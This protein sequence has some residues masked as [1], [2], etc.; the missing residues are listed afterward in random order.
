MP[1]YIDN[2]MIPFRGMQ[3]CHMAA[4]TEAEMHQMATIIGL[5]QEW[6]T[7]RC[8]AVPEEARAEAVKLGAREVSPREIVEVMQRGLPLVATDLLDEAKDL[9][10]EMEE[11]GDE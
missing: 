5:G 11:V 10:E 7:D 3:L 2:A 6:Y 9:I 1:V 4:D 8:Y